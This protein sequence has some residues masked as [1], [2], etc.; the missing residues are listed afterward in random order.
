M[1]MLDLDALFCSVDAFWCVF[2]PV[3]EREL[4]AAVRKRWRKRATRLHPSEIMTMVILVQHSGYRTF[5]AFY[6]QYVQ[7][8]LRAE[9]SRLVSY[10]RFVELLPRILLP[11]AVYLHTQQGSCSEHG[12]PVPISC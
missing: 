6:T 5:K 3:W 1:S 4:L 9:F 2:E 10:N 12:I 11:L 8:H 7:M